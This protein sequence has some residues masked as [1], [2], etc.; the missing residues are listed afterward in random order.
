MGVSTLLPDSVWQVD[1]AWE[2]LTIWFASSLLAFVW[3]LYHQHLEIVWLSLKPAI[4][5]HSEMIVS[6][7]ADY[8]HIAD[9]AAYAE[10]EAKAGG[11]LR[12][13]SH[14][15][16]TDMQERLPGHLER[17]WT[18]RM[19]EEAIEQ[20]S[21]GPVLKGYKSETE[22]AHRLRQAL[23]MLTEFERALRDRPSWRSTLHI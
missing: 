15:F 21:I 16:R 12:E 2:Y 13:V 3:I 10:W 9:D 20:R 22:F 18:P 14:R 11:C 8:A 23:D 4:D 5:Q 17:R 7:L 19:T 6:C 1:E